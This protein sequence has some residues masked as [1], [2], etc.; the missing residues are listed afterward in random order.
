MIDKFQNI[1]KKNFVYNQFLFSVLVIAYCSVYGMTAHMVLNGIQLMF[2]M[3]SFIYALTIFYVRDPI[4]KKDKAKKGIIYNQVFGTILVVSYIVLFGVSS[5]TLM[6]GFQLL[7]FMSSYVFAMSVFYLRDPERLKKQEDTPVSAT[8]SPFVE[9]NPCFIN[10][11]D[12]S[13]F[14]REVNG[15][16]STVI[17]FSEL[18]LSREYNEHEKEYMLRNI[19]ENAL[20]ISGNMDKVSLMINDSLTKPKEIHEVMDNLN[21]KILK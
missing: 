15:P 14:I 5:I 21:G 6:K 11:K 16:L 19:Y 4:L 18:M 2:F 8:Y 1:V 20:K 3:C 17:G 7:F 9:R 12:L 10:N 13:W